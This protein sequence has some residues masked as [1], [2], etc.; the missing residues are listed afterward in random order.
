MFD[1]NKKES[2]RTSAPLYAP[3]DAVAD[4]PVNIP[5]VF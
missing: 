4:F 2:M 3:G 5:P 1:A